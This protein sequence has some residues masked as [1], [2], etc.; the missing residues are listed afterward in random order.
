MGKPDS[1]ERIAWRPD[2]A[3]RARARL[4]QFISFCGLDSF[5]QMYRRSVADVSWFTA[6]LLEFLRI[7]F[8]PPYTKV[9]DLSRGM[10]WPRWCVGGGLNITNCLDAQ[11]KTRADQPAIIWE[12]EEGATRSLTY[13]ELSRD[14]GRCAAGLRLLGLGTGDA[15][16]IYLPMVPETAVALLAIGRIGA[17]AVPL[18]SGYGP[19]AIETRL[20]D[21]K[22][23]ALFVCDGF[24]RRGKL[25]PALAA[26]EEALARCPTVKQVIVV[27]RSLVAPTKR[28]TWHQLLESGTRTEPEPTAAEDPLLILY[29]SGTTGEPKGILHTHCGFPV[30]AAQDMAFGADVGPGDRILWVTD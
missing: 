23:K 18:F 28:M 16:G 27:R 25:V 4:T 26:A 3:P 15:I 22:A 5:D 1:A 14:V 30:K 8:D 24:F 17:I 13:A 21:V 2:E 7:P 9:V 11:V 29:T 6:R 12:G 20:N 10:A 19:Q